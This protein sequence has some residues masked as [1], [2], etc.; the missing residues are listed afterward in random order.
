MAAV[1]SHF[2]VCVNQHSE[3]GR[4]QTWTWASLLARDSRNPILFFPPQDGAAAGGKDRS[5][6]GKYMLVCQ[7]VSVITWQAL[8]RREQIGETVQR[9]ICSTQLKPLHWLLAATCLSLRVWLEAICSYSSNPCVCI[10][11]VWWDALQSIYSKCTHYIGRS[12]FKM[13]FISENEWTFF[14][15]WYSNL[16][17]LFL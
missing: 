1:L 7:Y 4:L 8:R 14:A 2:I 9:L 17:I 16:Y 13:S 5:D 15:I 6:R 3:E 12:A 10:N 11:V